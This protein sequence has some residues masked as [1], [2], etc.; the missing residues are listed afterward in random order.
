MNRYCVKD[1]LFLVCFAL[2]GTLFCQPIFSQGSVSLGGY[3]MGRGG[4]NTSFTA[5]SR[6]DF[7]FATL[8]DVGVEGSYTINSKKDAAV[9]ASVGVGNVAVRSLSFDPFSG[10]STNEFIM[11]VQAL[12]L[13][14]KLGL[15]FYNF[16]NI[17]PEFS[18]FFRGNI[19]LNMRYDA[20]VDV[21]N[22][23]TDVAASDGTLRQ[24]TLPQE[25][26][27]T[28]M[29]LGTE[30]G[31]ITIPLGDGRLSVYLQGGLAMTQLVKM[32]PL[33]RIPD[34]FN[35]VG[36]DPLAG[37]R[38]LNVQPISVGLGVRYVLDIL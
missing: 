19:P 18:L 2:I 10:R 33:T 37:L 31:I 8:P 23:T 28:F 20:T 34:N 36:K 6:G 24:Y 13:S 32:L 5:L 9:I 22:T 26:L 1:R 27:Q 4:W 11:N 29:E 15:R 21:F 12:C 17:F 3:V 30:I 38:T 7:A 25:R 16:L 14:S 35:I